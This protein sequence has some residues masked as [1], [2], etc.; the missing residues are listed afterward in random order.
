MRP[1]CNCILSSDRMLVG[2]MSG[3]TELPEIKIPSITLDLFSK[4]LSEVSQKG[5][6][7]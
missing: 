2:S 6:V 3:F 7:W 5:N 4:T 1:Y